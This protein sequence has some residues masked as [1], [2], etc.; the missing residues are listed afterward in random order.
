[1]SV[2]PPSTAKLLENRA[3]FL[4]FI[5]KRVGDRALAEDILQDA[6]ARGIAH[7]EA[8]DQAEDMVAW[9]YRVLRN[10][11]IDHHRRKDAAHR[12]LERLATE[13]D[14]GIVPPPEI[15]NVV[16]RCVARLATELKPEYERA[17]RR[18]EID[19]V[20]VKD[21]ARE[22]GITPSNAAVRV[23]RARRALMAEVQRSCGMCAT[24][25]CVDCTCRNSADRTS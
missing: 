5:E 3:E 4:S 12:G 17:L 11:V 2:Q 9:F 13:L 18:V 19:G 16:C 10:A 1:M 14:G 25:G 23:H 6:F 22:E 8:V 21:L 15:R 20:L 24:H 7:A